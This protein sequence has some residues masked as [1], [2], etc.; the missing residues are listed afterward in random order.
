MG[1]SKADA[2]ERKEGGDMVF[3]FGRVKGGGSSFTKTER[4]G[5]KKKEGKNAGHSPE[6]KKKEEATLTMP[7][8]SKAK[9]KSGLFR[10]GYVARE[11]SGLWFAKEKSCRSRE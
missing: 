1:R 6:E 3:H 2:V 4:R 8:D 9:K 11:R 10:T 7:T 5:K